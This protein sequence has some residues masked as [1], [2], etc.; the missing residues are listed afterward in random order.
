MKRLA[1]IVGWLLA[2]VLI[3]PAAV[4]QQGSTAAGSDKIQ[5]AQGS[6]AADSDKAQAQPADKASKTDKPVAQPDKTSQA[7]ETTDPNDPLF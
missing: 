2:A 6:T 4:A 3:V 5:P 1:V 7:T